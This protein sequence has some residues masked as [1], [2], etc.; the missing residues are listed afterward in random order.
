M[1]KPKPTKPAEY[2]RAARE[3]EAARAGQSTP[4]KVATLAVLSTFTAELLKPFLVVEAESL[5]CPL[6]PW[7]GP[8]GQLEQLVLDDR[9]ELWRQAPDVVW[10]A[11]RLEDVDRHLVHESAAIGPE[12]TRHRL[13]ALRQRVV[14][15]VRSARSKHRASILVSNWI[16]DARHNLNLFDASDADGFGHLVAEAN[17]H[18]AR[19]LAKIA[20][21]HVFDY[22]GIVAG[23]GALDWTDRRLWYMARSGSSPENLV[24]LARGLARATRALLRPAAKCLVLDLDNTL[25]GGVLGDDGAAGIKLGDDFPG[26]VFKDFQA[27][28]LGFRRRGI[29]LAIASKNDEQTVFDMLDSHPEMLLRREHFASIC[30]NWGGK[31][32]SLRKIARELNIGL[33]SLVFVDDNPVERAAVR[34]ELP[35]VHVVELPTDPLGYLAALGEVAVLDQPR[36]SA[37]DRARAEMYRGETLR[38]QVADQTGNLEDFLRD[39]DMVAQV[40][41]ASPNTLERIHQLIQKTNQFNLATRRHNLDDLR[42]LAASPDAAVAWLRLADRYGDLGLVCAGIIQRLDDDCWVIDTL[43]MSCRVMGRHVE[44]AFLSYLAELA[45]AAGARRLRGVFRPTAKNTPVQ[46]FYPDHGFTELTRNTE[47]HSYLAEIDDRAFAW[48][49]VIG[50]AS[51]EPQENVRV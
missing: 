28:L 35:M 7:F 29:L 50:R 45:R 11:L 23:R 8:F 9:S 6:R 31:P 22:A 25:W 20:D 43:L 39:L 38:R 1:Q 2:I 5:D 46:N 3:I 18:L 41:Q 47:E 48:P 4:E 34:A 40:G 14:G 33:D 13:D 21:A 16:S 17:R 12:E 15:L 19:D 10:I 42:R 24:P 49:M 30:A 27:A 32:D 36:L 37:E 51:P 26:N 44:D